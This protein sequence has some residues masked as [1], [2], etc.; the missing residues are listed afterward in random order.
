MPGNCVG[1]GDTSVSKTKQKYLLSWGLYSNV[2]RQ[3]INMVHNKLH[4]LERYNGCGKNKAREKRV[5]ILAMGAITILNPMF[6]EYL[7]EKVTF[8][9]GSGGL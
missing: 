2:V 6:Q 7:N 3:S 5:E 8:E 9:Q 4:I 1:A